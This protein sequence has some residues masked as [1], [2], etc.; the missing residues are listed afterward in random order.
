MKRP[1][2]YEVENPDYKKAKR[3]KKVYSPQPGTIKVTS[4]PP[5]KSLA[6]QIK[7]REKRQKEYE[8]NL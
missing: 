3:D 1:I 2:I 4:L 5:Q 8:N 7:D 6:E